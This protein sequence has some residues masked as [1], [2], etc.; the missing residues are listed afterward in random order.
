MPFGRI[1]VGVDGTDQSLAACRQAARLAEEGGFIEVVTVVNLAE[2]VLVGPGA[3]R[4]ADELRQE[5]ESALDEAIQIFGDRAERRLLQGLPTPELLAEVR[6]V[7][8]TLL[9]IG[10]H[11][12]SRASE[13]V[14]GG[15]AGELLHQAPVQQSWWRARPTTHSGS[16]VRSPLASTARPTPMR[17]SP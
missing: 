12:H 2:A 13:I 3:P 1:L 6:R 7:H 16:H 5:A 4:M 17:H 14:L 8:A 10:S 15:A 9:A 11:G